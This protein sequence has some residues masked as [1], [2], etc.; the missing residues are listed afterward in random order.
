[1]NSSVAM[2][3][4]VDLYAQPF[5]VIDSGLSVRL[6]NRAFEN[7]YGVARD[8][9]VGRRCYEL[10]PGGPRACPCGPEGAHC[11]FREVFTGAKGGVSVHMYEGEQ[12]EERL[13]RIQGHPLLTASGEIL[14][15]ELIQSD[16]PVGPALEDADT[17]SDG[18]PR[19]VGESGLFRQVLGQLRLAARSAAPILLEG[20]TGTGKELAAGYIHRHSDRAVGPFVTLDCTTLGEDLFESEVFGH[21]RGSFTGSVGER[22]GLFEQAHGGTL[23]LDEIGEMPLPLQAKLLRALE[24]G[25]FR[26]VGSDVTRRADVRIVCATNRDLRDSSGF[27]QDLYFRIACMRVRMP[28]LAERTEDIPALA[29]ELLL[30][31]GA[32]A[33]RPL[34]LDPDSWS[35][36]S[37]IPSWKHPRAAQRAVGRRDA[38]R[39][40]TSRRNRSRWLYKSTPERLKWHQNPPA[41]AC[42]F[43]LPYPP[44][45]PFP[46]PCGTSRVST[47]AAS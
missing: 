38:Q 16:T 35:C 3:S 31:I 28:S 7:A 42:L 29:R 10:R 36:C 2:Q 43:L 33:D 26:R 25:E 8:H 39:R 20:A 4:L 44:P 22:K 24:S 41:R 23:F 15:G 9:A 11:P 30:R 46:P 40:R 19:M 1:M 14:L 45:P 5:V 47:C 13:V 12:G 32:L 21:E 27:R 37:L 6:V 34:E 18:A 17:E